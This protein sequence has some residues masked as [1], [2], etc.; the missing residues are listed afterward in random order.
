[1]SKSST[2][3]EEPVRRRRYDST[4]RRRQAAANRVR[5]VAAGADLVRSLSTWDWDE[6]TFRAVAERAGV[7]ERTVYRNFPTERLLHDAVMA[8]LQQDAGVSY[9][10]L[11]LADVAKVT[12]QVFSAVRQFAVEESIH[13]PSFPT[14]TEEV[15]R[16]ENALIQAIGARAPEWPDDQRTAIAGLLDMLWNPLTYERLVQVWK[17]DD[18][19]AIEAVQW[20]I[21]KVVDAVEN[22]E[23]PLAKRRRRRRNTNT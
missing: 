9:E 15:R 6:V 17:L 4:A 2:P 3:S 16:R 13:L 12:A 7:S 21:G 10:N 14:F 23:Q 11:D 19:R 1:M 5:I 22:N 20:L 8:R 18:A